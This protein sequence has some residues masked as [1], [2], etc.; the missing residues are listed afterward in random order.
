MPGEPFPRI[1][2]TTLVKFIARMAA[3]GIDRRTAR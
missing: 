1:V 3:V 2:W